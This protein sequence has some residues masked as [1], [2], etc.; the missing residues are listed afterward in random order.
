[1]K[2]IRVF[3]VDDHELIRMGIGEAIDREDDLM[4]VGAAASVGEALNVVG[5]KGPD[6]AVLDFRLPDGDG[7]ELCRE[8]RS[9]YPSVKCLLFTSFADDE[10]VLQAVMAGASGFMLKDAK[11]DL[12]I[13][14]IRD[15][16]KGMSLIAPETVQKVI[17]RVAKGSIQDQ[18][19]RSLTEQ[20]RKIL[21]LIGGGKTNREIATE[22]F[23]AEQTVKNHVSNLLKKLDMQR[24]TQAAVFA[25]ELDRQ[26]LTYESEKDDKG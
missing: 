2:P 8:I 22:L 7:I 11:V 26:H 21:R 16:G 15:I 24:R 13:R 9:R 12:L 18:R 23:L 1:M 3:V 6:V 4:F 19:A 10:A 25:S 17:E 20:E 14:S 5:L